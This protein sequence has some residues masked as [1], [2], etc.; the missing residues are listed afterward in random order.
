MILHD[1]LIRTMAQS[2]G[3]I[4]PFVDDLVDTNVL[5]YGLSSF[6]YDIR[7]GKEYWLAKPREGQ[8]DPKAMAPDDF[9]VKTGDAVLLPGNSYM[10]AE[11]VEYIK[12]P[13]AVT[14]VLHCKSTYIRA[15]I[16][17]PTTVLEAGWEGS[18]TLEIVNV[19]PRPVWVHGG[20]GIAQ[21]MFFAGNEPEVTYAER[22]GKYHVQRG[23]TLPR[24]RW[25]ARPEG[26]A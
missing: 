25:A 6:G 8:V 10:L 22:K 19:S 13:S 9:E 1:K 12:M 17:I 7:I 23:I 20:E 11:S 5:S 14:G 4:D 15:G 24:V 2:H 21:I 26:Q 16:L 18:I 3:M